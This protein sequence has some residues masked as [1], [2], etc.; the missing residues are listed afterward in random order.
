MFVVGLPL[1]ILVATVGFR[2]IEGPSLDKVR[3]VK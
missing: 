1:S 3:A 2:Y